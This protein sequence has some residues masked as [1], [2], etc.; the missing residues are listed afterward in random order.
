MG[1]FSTKY[2]LSKNPSLSRENYKL[3]AHT[4]RKISKLNAKMKKHKCN[5]PELTPTPLE[6]SGGKDFDGNAQ[7]NE[8]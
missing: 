3:H 5:V 8:Y 2:K 1:R 7:I 4:P 6:P